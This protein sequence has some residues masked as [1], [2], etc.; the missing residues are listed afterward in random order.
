MP[1]RLKMKYARLAL[2]LFYHSKCYY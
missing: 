2:E 1:G